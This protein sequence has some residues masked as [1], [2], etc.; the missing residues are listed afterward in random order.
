MRHP[1]VGAHSLPS[2]AV[3]LPCQYVCG[4]CVGGCYCHTAMF[5]KA[6]PSPL[7]GPSP[8]AVLRVV[9]C[10]VCR[11][12][13]LRGGVSCVVG[14]CCVVCRGAVFHGAWY[15]VGLCCVLRGVSWGCVAWWCVV[16][17]GAVLRGAWCAVGLCCVVCGVSWGCVAWCVVCCGHAQGKSCPRL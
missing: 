10:V 1:T 16:R 3:I 9:W 11:G 2:A 4:V 8:R 13:V 15:V 7:A 14:L 12:A 5:E 17:G 6:G